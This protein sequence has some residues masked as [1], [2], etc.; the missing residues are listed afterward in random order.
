MHLAPGVHDLALSY[1]RPDGALEI[2]PAAVE[3]PRGVLLVDVGLELS[4]LTQ[5]LE[6]HGLDLDSVTGVLL[7][8]QDGDHV[9]AL[10]ALLSETDASVMA[11]REATPYID[12]RE[13][14]VKGDRRYDPVPVDLELQDGVRIRTDAGPMEVVFTPGHAPGHV[15]LFFPDHGTLLAGDAV[16]AVDGELAGPSEEFT[17]NRERALDS[18]RHLASYDIERVLCYHGGAVLGTDEDLSTVAEDG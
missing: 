11:H 13:A 4:V 12:G 7:T 6:T 1:E 17:P 16:T 3:T 18:V 8:H 5:G 2:H 15:S 9:G 10:P 14:L